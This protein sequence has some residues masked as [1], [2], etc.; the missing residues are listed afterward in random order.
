MMA[1][2]ESKGYKTDDPGAIAI[3]A[4]KSATS[5]ERMLGAGR[6]RLLTIPRDAADEDGWKNVF[7]KLGVPAE[8]KEYD[9]NGIKFGD[10]DL[11]PSFSDVMRSALHKAGVVKDKAPDVVKAVVKW[12]SDAESADATE[13]TAKRASERERLLKNWGNQAEFNRLTAMQG[14]RRVGAT[15]EDV[16]RFES[17][18][19][20]DRT[21]ELF[22][23]IGAGTTEDSFVESRQ[24]GM[25]TTATGAAERR[26]ELMKDSD[27]AKRY[28]SGGAAEVREMNALNRLIAEAAE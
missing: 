14:A 26:A 27:W 7:S 28:L 17:V 13:T 9:F 2:W 3:E 18:L 12:L 24:G 5:L 8:P 23:K 19:G 16:A 6:D 25:V 22:R 20:Y 15:E 4:T 1:Y 21:M 11:D 10:A